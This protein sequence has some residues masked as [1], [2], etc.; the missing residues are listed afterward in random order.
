MTG[1][2]SLIELETASRQRS[3]SQA[4]SR[5]PNLTAII[6]LP[7]ENVGSRDVAVQDSSLGGRGPESNLWLRHLLHGLD[8]LG[9]LMKPWFLTL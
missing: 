8:M 1:A 7:S 4:T 9:E 2:K 6:M 3:R 5:L